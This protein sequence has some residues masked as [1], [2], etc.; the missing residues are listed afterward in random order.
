MVTIIKR[1]AFIHSRSRM[2]YA[3][4][5]YFE[6]CCPAGDIVLPFFVSKPLPF[7]RDKLLKS[8][9]QRSQERSVCKGN[10]FFIIFFCHFLLSNTLVTCP[11]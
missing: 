8:D 7:A 2:L 4:T 9:N 10:T 11:I 1:F 3:G 5:L 6:S